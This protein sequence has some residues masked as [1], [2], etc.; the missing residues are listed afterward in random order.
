MRP[1]SLSTLGELFKKGDFILMCC[2]CGHREV[3]FHHNVIYKNNQ[4]DE[5]FTILP[6]CKT[7][8]DRANE[9]EVRDKLDWVMCRRATDEELKSI[10]K[11]TDWIKR[12]DF[13]N[14][15]FRDESL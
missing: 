4:S 14:Q 10:S 13:L 15:K 8:H 2:L 11:V 12:R 6:V 9:K 1:I 5:P 7:C 3:Q